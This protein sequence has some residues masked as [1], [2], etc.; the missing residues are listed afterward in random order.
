MTKPVLEAVKEAANAGHA[1]ALGPGAVHNLQLEIEVLAAEITVSRRLRAAHKA[2]VDSIFAHQ[3]ANT[4]PGEEE[5][6]RL[7]AEWQEAE[8]AFK[9]EITPSEPSAVP[10]STQAE[11]DRLRQWVADLQ[12]G[13]YVNC[14]YCGHRYGPGETTPVR[15]ADALKA[16]IEQCQAHPMSALKTEIDRLRKY[17]RHLKECEPYVE[18][19]CHCT[20]GLSSVPESSTP[21]NPHNARNR[22][23]TYDLSDEPRI[24]PVDSDRI[25]DVRVAGGKLNLIIG[26]VDHKATS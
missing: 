20:C 2:V 23:F 12:S 26:P 3:E 21:I 18:G 5:K 14:V 16:H 1:L 8:R 24:V 10:A 13:L 4:Q 6:S 15:M 22:L 17:V 25:R 9:A 7:M 11:N 19:G